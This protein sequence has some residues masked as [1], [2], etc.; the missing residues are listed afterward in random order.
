MIAVFGATGK[1][2][3]QI[4]RL[5]RERGAAVRAVSRDQ[6]CLGDALAR[7]AVGCVADLRRPETLP[8]TLAGVRVVVTTANA[9]LGRGDNDLRRVDLEGNAALL[10]AARRA[11]VERVVFISAMG[12]H[13]RHPV[14]LF[15]AK[16]ATEARL[17]SSGMGG[18]VVSAAPFMETWAAMLGEPVLQG[19]RVSLRGRGDNPVP[20]VSRQDVARV[21]VEAAL[22]PQ[23]GGIERI[24]LGG[25]ER[26]TAREVVDVYATLSGRAP[27]LRHQWRPIL[28]ALGTVARPFD[29]VR[30]RLLAAALWIEAADHPPTPPEVV[31]RYG[32]L[33]SLA[34]LVRA[35]L[36]AR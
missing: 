25:P 19:R 13:S 15:R 36:G 26:L 22:S 17:A 1:L 3:A 14:D 8:A 16:A 27:R 24:P 29:P 4:V 35:R 10:D 28:A 9:V 33:R 18:T 32:P 30:A 12:A 5:L 2:G 21:A 20:F 11:G 6:A 34:D 23:E 31:S 7:G